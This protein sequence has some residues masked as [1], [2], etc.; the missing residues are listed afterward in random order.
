MIAVLIV[1]SITSLHD[2]VRIESCVLSQSE[3]LGRQSQ[4]EFEALILFLVI[5]HSENVIPPSAIYHF[6]VKLDKFVDHH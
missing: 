6:S 5:Y 1:S 2:G 4:L 3:P